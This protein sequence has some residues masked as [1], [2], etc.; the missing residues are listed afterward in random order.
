MDVIQIGA[1][2]IQ[3]AMLVSVASLLIGVVAISFRARMEGASRAWTDWALAVVI[4]LMLN[5]KIG[6][7]WDSPSIIWE[8][9]SAML[10]LSGTSTNGNI[11]L[12]I[13]LAAWTAVYL[14]K[15]QLSVLMLADLAVHGVLAA[16]AA[17]GWVYTLNGSSAPSFTSLPLPSGMT[18]DGIPPLES[19]L[20]VVMLCMLWLSR[21]SLG[22]LY[23]ARV[24]ALAWGIIGMLTSLV[25]IHDSLVLGLAPAQWMF[26][27]LLAI[28]FVMTRYKERI[29]ADSTGSTES[30]VATELLEA[31]ETNDA[32]ALKDA[33]ESI[34]SSER[35]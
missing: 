2:T 7:L 18:P 6:Y 15:H 11:L 27:G 10:Y 32:T 25:K 5:E 33:T 24:V 23:D 29:L 1:V 21:R 9:T 14:R 8:Q 19:L 26:G 3:W 13:G 31:T 12:V 20:C 4:M 17:Y 16:V 34:K 35:T 28:A 22:S 30:N